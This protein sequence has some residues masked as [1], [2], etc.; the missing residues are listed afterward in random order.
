MHMIYD[1]YHIHSI[2]L[3]LLTLKFVNICYTGSRSQLPL[4][5]FVLLVV[6]EGVISEKDIKRSYCW[7]QESK[8]REVGR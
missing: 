4:T 5:S 6:F 3:Y 8:C 1:I 2:H 7:N